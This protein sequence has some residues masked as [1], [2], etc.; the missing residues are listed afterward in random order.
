MGGVGTGSAVVAGYAKDHI[1][2]NTQGLG[3]M[4][5]GWM[6]GSGIYAVVVVEP[7]SARTVLPFSVS[8]LP[9]AIYAWWLVAVGDGPMDAT[10]MLRNA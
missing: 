2:H 8:A 1:R 10:W 4:V 3:W 5:I 6:D 7:T 9:T